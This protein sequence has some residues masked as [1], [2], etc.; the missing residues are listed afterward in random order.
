VNLADLSVDSAVNHSS[1][2]HLI[3]ISGKIVI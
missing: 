1:M 3:L 2:I